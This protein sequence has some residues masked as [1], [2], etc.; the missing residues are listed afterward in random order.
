MVAIS[1]LNRWPKQRTDKPMLAD[2]ENQ[3]ALTASSCAPIPALVAGE[4]MRSS[5]RP[6]VWSLDERR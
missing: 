4:L 2:L 6:M 5:E 1:Q 3:A